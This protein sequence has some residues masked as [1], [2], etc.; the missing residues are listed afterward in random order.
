MMRLK[1]LL[2]LQLREQELC[3]LLKGDLYDRFHGRSRFSFMHHTKKCSVFTSLNC[4]FYFLVQC[5]GLIIFKNISASMKYLGECQR[6]KIGIK[7][8]INLYV[9][10]IDAQKICMVNCP[11]M[12]GIIL[13]MRVLLRPSGKRMESYNFDKYFTFWRKMYPLMPL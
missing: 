7:F 13:G 6:M 12:L 9:P 2:Q 10:Q 3:C 1:V 8:R 5:F 4:G 11:M